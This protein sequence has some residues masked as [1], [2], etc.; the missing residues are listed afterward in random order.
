MLK[1]VIDTN[2]KTAGTGTKYG[3]GASA[4]TIKALLRNEF[5]SFESID[6]LD[7]MESVLRSEK[8]RSVHRWNDQ[9]LDYFCDHWASHCTLIEA[10]R[11]VAAVICRDITDVKFLDLAIA[12]DADYLVTFDRRHLLPLKKIGRTRIVTPHKFLLALRK[13]QLTP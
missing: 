11:T 10:P 12:G 3:D 5:Q 7:E 8:A 9:Q 1:A 13:D 2:I 6:T 4:M